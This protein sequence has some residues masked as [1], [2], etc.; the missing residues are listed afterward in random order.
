M[1]I[2]N[3]KVSAVLWKRNGGKDIVLNVTF[4]DAL[5]RCGVA[6]FLPILA[7]IITKKWVIYT[8]PVMFYLFVSA[9]VR[10]CLIKYTWHRFIIGDRGPAI[11]DYGKD[12]NYPEESL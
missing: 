9:L 2:I 12:V 11:K 8:T 4:K 6:I 7:M 5:I 10:F 1:K 3:P